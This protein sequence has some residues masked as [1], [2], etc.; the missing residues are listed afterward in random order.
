M[1]NNSSA[2]LIFFLAMVLFPDAQQKAQDEIDTVI[3]LDRLPTFADRKSL[4]YVSALVYEI[5]RWHPS[6]PLGMQISLLLISP[7]DELEQEYLTP[8]PLTTCTKVTI[9]PK[10]CRCSFA[11][12]CHSNSFR[13]NPFVQY[14]VRSRRPVLAF[15]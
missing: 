6:I 3:G 7:S 4:P 11:R 13:G 5:L 12:N 8:W 2:L 1:E 10:V 9:C 14:M 15:K